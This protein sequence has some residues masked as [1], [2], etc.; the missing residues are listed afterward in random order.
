MFQLNSG[1]YFSF[2]VYLF[3]LDCFY[4]I[5]I[6]WHGNWLNIEHWAMIKMFWQL[7]EK[8]LG[9]LH[10]R[11]DIPT[12]I[13]DVI[14]VDAGDSSSQGSSHELLPMP[15][16]VEVDAKFLHFVVRRNFIIA[17]SNRSGEKKLLKWIANELIGIDV[18]DWLLLERHLVIIIG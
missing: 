12:G 8:C 2:L 3:I 10:D 7:V 13:H 4:V 6:L 18:S 5:A 17:T 14:R 16:P 15:T 9:C 1:K 11:F